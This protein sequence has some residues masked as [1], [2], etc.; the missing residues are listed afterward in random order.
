MPVAGVPSGA[1]TA[2]PL[3]PAEGEGPALIWP[4]PEPETPALQT[5]PAAAQTS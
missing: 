5:S 4:T 1:L 3:A 2:M